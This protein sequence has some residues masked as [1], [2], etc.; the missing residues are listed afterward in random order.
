[1]RL[2]L[3]FLLAACGAVMDAQQALAI[4]SNGWAIYS[5]RSA[6]LLRAKASSE[7]G[8]Q[9]IQYADQA[10]NGTPHPMARV[11][12]EG[13]LNGQ[14]IRDQSILAERD[15]T[16]A[17]NLG[18]AYRLTGDKK[19]VSAADRYLGA[20]FA[21]YKP[22]FNPIDETPIDQLMMAYEL[23]TGKLSETTERQ[24]VELWRSFAEGYIGWMEQQGTTN[25]TNWSSHR[26]KLGVMAAYLLGDAKLEARGAVVFRDQLNRNMHSDGSVMDF[27]LRDA[28]HYV[29]YDLDPLL[30][31]ALVAQ[32]HGQD[33]F[34]TGEDGKNLADGVDWFV[35][36]E[37]GEKKH[38][39]FV[40]SR[41]PIDA[42]RA[43]MNYK[44]FAGPWDPADG[45]DTLAL[46]TLMDSHFD[47]ALEKTIKQTGH[48][49]R[50]WMELLPEK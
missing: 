3:L 19:Y 6:E 21:I 24:A 37:T 49:P 44:G 46:A 45:V 22:D 34:H 38:E 4:K 14:G 7:A 39:E 15:W 26:V 18:L 40:H 28:L 12:T 31:A 1:M 30:M 9:A 10:L 35:P 16:A 23:T 11:H 2:M 33:W 13:T 17:L 8:K 47:L 50:V 41:V 20:W 27:Y 42:A 29:F 5:P 36:Y 32:R 25:I 48:A 43:K